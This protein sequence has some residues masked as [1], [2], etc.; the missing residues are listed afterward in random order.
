MYI[1]IYIYNRDIQRII[2]DLTIISTS[3]LSEKPWMLEKK[4]SCQRDEIQGLFET[5]GLF[6][7]K[8]GE[9]IAK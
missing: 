5:Q 2:A 3:T 1:Y 4:L 8:V 7:V 6:E 9:L